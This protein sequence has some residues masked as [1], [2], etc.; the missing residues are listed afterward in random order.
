MKKNNLLLIQPH[1]D[2]IIFSAS[3]FLYE[4][5]KY[6]EVIILTVE[7]DEKRL[8]EDKK[9]CEK[10]NVEL[11]T[12]DTKVSS[13]NFHKEYYNLHTE[14][15]VKS[16]WKFCESK[17][18]SIDLDLLSREL[19]EL[20]TLIKPTYKIVT[21]LG[22]GHPFHFLVTKLTKEYADLFYRDFPHSYKKR[23]KAY[24]NGIT[25]S[26]FQLKNTFDINNFDK[27][28]LVKECYKSQSS[29]LFFEKNYIDKMLPEEYYEKIKN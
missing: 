17:I 5:E 16:A 25:N 22:V 18:G 29:L 21:C 2:D 26:E 24:F 6:D 11:L 7:Y 3:K 9:L 8:E 19:D 13:L 14:M 4:R 28:S 23:N 15:D 27:F 10:F 20:L 12:L 1:S